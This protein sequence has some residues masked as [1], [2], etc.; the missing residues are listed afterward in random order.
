MLLLIMAAV[1]TAAA[2]EIPLPPPRPP[3]REIA[4]ETPHGPETDCDRRLAKIA[5]FDPKPTVEGPGQCGGRDLISLAAVQLANGRTVDIV[6][7]PV[8]RCEMAEALALWVREDVAPRL[9]SEGRALSKVQQVDAY[10][11]RPRAGGGKISEHGHG[12]AIDIQAFVFDNKRRLAPTDMNEPKEVRADLRESACLR[13]T[14]VLGPGEPNHDSHI[15][16][17]VLERKRGYRICAWDVR[18]PPPPV[19]AKSDHASTVGAAV[20]S[21]PLPVPSPR[22]QSRAAGPNAKAAPCGAASFSRIEPK[23]R[24]YRTAGSCRRSAD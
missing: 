3:I 16:L 2:A 15:H 24:I 19:V 21:V 22:K 11:C 1:A 13:F 14:T 18:E 23:L 17:D 4:I 9:A 6:P 5:W 20:Q 10:T 12:N 8:L 7:R